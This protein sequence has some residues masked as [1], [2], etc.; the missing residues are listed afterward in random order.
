MASTFLTRP[1]GAAMQVKVRALIRHGERIVVAVESRRGGEKHI[2]LPGGRPKPGEGLVDALVREV[3][4]ETGLHVNVGR[5]LYVAEAVNGHHTDD[6]NLVFAAAT[7][8]PIDE[9][10]AQLIEPTE[11]HDP[12]VLPPILDVIAQDA[13]GPEGARWLGNVWQPSSSPM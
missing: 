12:P 11:A 5:L 10:R 4:E 7:A 2:T 3:R 8:E 9:G 13:G 1:G 6:L